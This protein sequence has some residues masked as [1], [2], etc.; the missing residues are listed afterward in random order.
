MVS[1]GDNLTDVLGSSPAIAV[2]IS[3]SSPLT[4]TVRM[5]GAIIN[6]VEKSFSP[7]EVKPGQPVVE[8]VGTSVEVAGRQGSLMDAA[9]SILP[10]VA[11]V[12]AFALVADNT[13]PP[14]TQEQIR[15]ANVAADAQRLAGIKEEDAKKAEAGLKEQQRIAFFQRKPPGR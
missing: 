1:T 9:L 12:G 7:P 15:E 4:Q 2:T 8:A 14:P 13:S 3:P 5:M 11:V 6:A 10:G